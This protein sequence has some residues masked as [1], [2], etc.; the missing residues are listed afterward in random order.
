MAKNS[1]TVSGDKINRDGHL[2]DQVEITFNKLNNQLII[3]ISARKAHNSHLTYA[4]PKAV[5]EKG[6]L[7]MF[8]KGQGESD[9]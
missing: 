5:A 9:S 3:H 1:F 8:T 2:L 7:E 4:L 6:F